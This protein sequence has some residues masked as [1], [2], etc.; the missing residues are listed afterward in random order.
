MTGRGVS[1]NKAE[2]AQWFKK[3]ADQ[4]HAYAQAQLGTGASY[5]NGSRRNSISLKFSYGGDCLEVT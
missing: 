2:A 5:F 1:A 3:A 4:W